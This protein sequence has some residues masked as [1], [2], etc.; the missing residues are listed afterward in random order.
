MLALIFLDLDRFKTINDTLGHTLGDRLLREVSDRLTNCL[1]KGDTISRL[2][3]DEFTI[4]LPKVNHVKD[5]AKI[6]QRILD[7]LKSPFYLDGHEL[8]VTTSLG[9]AFYPTDGQDTQTL[10]KNADIAMYRAKEQGGNNYQF[11]TPAMN[12]AA[13]ERLVL[14]TKLRRA[15]EQE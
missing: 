3:G 6:A 15:V 12:T 11:Y 13:L 7:T 5:I 10:L 1:R 14:E 8:H 2:G 4:L 9:I